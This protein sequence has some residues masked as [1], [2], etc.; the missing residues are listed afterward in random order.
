MARPRGSSARPPAKSIL[1]VIP[2]RV[3]RAAAQVG[4]LPGVYGVFCR[5]TAAPGGPPYMLVAHV[6]A[7]PPDAEL[8]D[9]GL[10]RLPSSFDTTSLGPGIAL[11]PADAL[12]ELDSLPVQFAAVGQPRAHQLD[13]QSAAR[14]PGTTRHGTFTVLAKGDDGARA[15]LSGHVCLPH[16]V[17]DYPGNGAPQ[18]VKID[19][20]QGQQVQ[21]TAR[22]LRG[23]LGGQV[24]FGLAHFP[25]AKPADTDPTQRAADDTPPLRRRRSVLAVD[26]PVHHFSR[27]RNKID[28]IIREFAAA[29]VKLEVGDELVEYTGI[30][31]V[32]T[33]PGAPAD[34]HFSLP[35]ESGSL[36]VDDSRR[37]WGVILGASKDLTS[38]YVLTLPPLLNK[39]GADA[40]RFFVP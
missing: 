32:K 13:W 33:M 28:G 11:G 26:E 7:P 24:D 37:A 19:A 6:S 40:D 9:H 4:A 22:L 17:H 16:H 10:E 35:G 34:H 15:L 14:M 8:D 29:P 21:H 5:R 3:R 2:A 12:A 31:V 18:D 1:P 38:A 27:E 36:V 25:T 30:V 23:S 20:A 39:L